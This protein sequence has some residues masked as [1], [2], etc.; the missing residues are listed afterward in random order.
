MEEKALT[1]LLKAGMPS[2]SLLLTPLAILSFLNTP[3]VGGSGTI[4]QAQW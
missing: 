4:A 3:P 2:L 1:K